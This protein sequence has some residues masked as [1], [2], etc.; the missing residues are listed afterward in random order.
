MRSKLQ[1]S[2]PLVT[3]SD[4]SDQSTSQCKS[5]KGNILV[6]WWDVLL[7]L[8]RHADWHRVFQR[9]QTSTNPLSS[10]QYTILHHADTM[11]IKFDDL[12]LQRPGPP[13]NAWGLY[14]KDDELGRLNLITPEV[15]KRGLEEVKH[16][17]AINLKSVP[18]LV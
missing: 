3:A 4:R 18:L 16:G 14:G 12:P 6:A 1:S 5:T 11:E 2:P 13:L 17:I 7:R 9:H 15:V 8:F 10:L